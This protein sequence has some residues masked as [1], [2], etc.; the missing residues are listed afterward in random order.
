MAATPI[1][2]NARVSRSSP[3][4]T[5]AFARGWKALSATLVRWSRAHD[6]RRHLEYLDDHILRDIGFDP[7]EA[8]GEAAKQFW[9]PYTLTSR[10]D[11]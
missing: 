1:L 7:R 8:R 3:G 4:S 6:A 11:R 5:S 2:E 9:E 10:C